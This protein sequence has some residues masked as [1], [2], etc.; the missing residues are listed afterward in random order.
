MGSQRFQERF[1]C[2][3]SKFNYRLDL[4]QS[5]PGGVKISRGPAT[6]HSAVS[7]AIAIYQDQ[8]VFLDNL[9]SL[10][11]NCCLPPS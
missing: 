9:K 6:H 5:E 2:G 4:A 11:T 10:I 3:L 7:R 8:A 1:S